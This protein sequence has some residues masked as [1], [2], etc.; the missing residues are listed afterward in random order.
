VPDVLA[1]PAVS[2]V[3]V[4]PPPPT[5]PRPVQQH[6][7]APR[8]PQEAGRAEAASPPQSAASST[9]RPRQ[10]TPVP[11]AAPAPPPSYIALLLGALERHKAY[12]AEARSRRAQGVALLRFRMRRDG[13][14]A[15][16][17]IERS[18]GDALL[19]EAV[20]GMLQRA[21]PLPAPPPELPGETIELTVPVRF[22]LR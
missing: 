16:Y 15:D 21:S 5:L 22:A 9:A 2:P 8:R 17:R 4:P 3:V 12:P 10:A 19:D 18:T 1:T 20:V 7:P 6:R 13:T 14:V 11:T